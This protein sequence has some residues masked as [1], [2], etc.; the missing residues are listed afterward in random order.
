MFRQRDFDIWKSEVNIILDIL[1]CSVR[2]TDDFL[3][4]L[5]AEGKNPVSAAFTI[6]YLGDK[7]GFQDAKT[8]EDL[9]FESGCDMAKDTRVRKT[10]KLPGDLKSVGDEGTLKGFLNH[11]RKIPIYLVQFDGD[12]FANGVNRETI[13]EIK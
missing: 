9:P 6:S 10:K 8:V 5:F 3:L 12:N 13:E 4:I 1:N 7:L 11:D 2:T